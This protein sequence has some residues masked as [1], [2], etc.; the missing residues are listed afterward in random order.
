[1]EKNLEQIV[2]VTFATLGVMCISSGI[3]MTK[4][5]PTIDVTS[6]VTQLTV[7]QKRVKEIKNNEITPKNITL[8][9]NSSLSTNIKDYLKNP[10]DIDT[11]VI[12][13]LKLDTSNVNTNE[14]GKYTYKIKYK[15]KTYNGTIEI[16]D[17]EEKKVENLTLDT[18]SYE[19]GSQLSNDISTYVKET[20]TD[21]QKAQIKLEL[22]K[23]DVSKPGNYQY[24][25]NY[26]GKIYTSTITIYEPKY[27]TN[28]IIIENAKTT[29]VVIENNNNNNENENI[30]P[31]NDNSNTN[32][33]E[34]NNNENTDTNTN[35]NELDQNNDQT[36]N[37]ENNQ[38]ENPS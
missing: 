32:N 15:K 12:K 19:V 6:K 21:E 36:S 24:Y 33:S 14:E 35:T 30:T 22:S 38:N 26:N 29:N 31:S 25:V 5:T 23:V 13:S 1:M 17:K 3:A 11:S 16:K 8:E 37:N 28:S 27:G 34:I 20:L 4:M 2:A 9:I 7:T 10:N 18:P